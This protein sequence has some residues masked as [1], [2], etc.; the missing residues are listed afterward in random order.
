MKIQLVACTMLVACGGDSQPAVD[1]GSDAVIDSA[2]GCARAPAA[3]DR[4]RFV[5]IAHPYDKDGKSLPAFEVLELSAAG[6]LTRSSPPRTFMLGFRMPFGNISFTPDGKIGLAPLDNG[7]LGI[8]ALAADGTPTVLDPGFTGSF[9]ADRVV[10]HPSGE[11]AWVVDTNTRENG[12]GI[13]E[14]EIACDGQIVDRGQVAAARSPGGLAFAGTR[15]VIAA[16]DVL[17][18]PKTGSDL[19]VL[20]FTTTAPTYAAGGDVFG[21]DDQMFSG[22]ALSRDGST[23]FVGDS[24]FGGTNRV[25]VAAIGASGV[26]ARQVITMITDP[27][28]IAASP[29]GDAAIVTSSQPPGEGIYVLDTGGSGGAWRNRGKLAVIGGNAELPGDLVQIDRGALDGRVLIS[30]LSRIRQVTFAAGGAVNDAGSL[31]F[32]SGLD[33]ICGAIGV[34]P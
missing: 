21:D 14:I 22:F 20:D 2:S 32:G 16:R 7:K 29:F 17:D 24:N 33:E 10:M 8:F 5:V 34:Q 9:Y 4:T 12:G 15:G 31:V 26:S 27:S 11:R 28:G 3:A 6:M 23:A 18:S 13:Y 25:A 1:G 30:E 19:H